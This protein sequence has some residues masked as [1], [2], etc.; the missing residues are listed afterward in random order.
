LSDYLTYVSQLTSVQSLE[1]QIVQERG[2]L[3]TDRVDL[4]RALGGDWTKKLRPLA[5][6]KEQTSPDGD[7]SLQ[8]S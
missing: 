6:V 2:T 4:H 7:K 8:G 3:L 1:R 5:K